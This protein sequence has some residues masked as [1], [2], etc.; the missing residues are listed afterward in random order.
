[1]AHNF[2]AFSRKS[3]LGPLKSSYKLSPRTVELEMHSACLRSTFGNDAGSCQSLACL[4]E[5]RGSLAIRRYWCGANGVAEVEHRQRSRRCGLQHSE[6]GVP[7]GAA[8][9][10]VDV[11]KSSSA[12]VNVRR[13]G[14][15]CGASSVRGTLTIFGQTWRENGP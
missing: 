2:V 5:T 14:V 7:L 9:E 4:S 1:M 10:W 3:L 6:L 11:A 15:R 8:E 12:G 13:T